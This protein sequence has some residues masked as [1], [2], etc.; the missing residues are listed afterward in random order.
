MGEIQKIAKCR[1]KQSELWKILFERALGLLPDKEVE[2]LKIS[3]EIEKNNF[4][5]DNH[6]TEGSQE[7][8]KNHK[9]SLQSA[10]TML[11]NENLNLKIKLERIQKLHENETENL[12]K[13]LESL[14]SSFVIE[15]KLK[16]KIEQEKNKEIEQLKTRLRQEE[17]KKDEARLSCSMEI[18]AAKIRFENEMITQNSL[19]QNKND[20]LVD[21]IK[22]LNDI[23]RSLHDEKTEMLKK[24]Y[25]EKDKRE[26]EI[27]IT[28]ENLAPLKKLERL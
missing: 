7:K 21:E 17:E 8:S 28:N 26:K 20:E 15:K 24:L 22:R 5:E 1:R 16:S 9:E 10:I 12:R 25:N 23:I 4:L 27:N 18:N 3:K 14:G 13:E 11:N 6:L 2:L 19:M